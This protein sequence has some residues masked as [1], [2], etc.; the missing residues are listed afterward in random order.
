MQVIPS[1]IHIPPGLI[2]TIE[3]HHFVSR[4]PDG[5]QVS[6]AVAVQ[7][8][9]DSYEGSPAQL[10]FLKDRKRDA[11]AQ[12][13]GGKIEAGRVYGG[14]TFQIDQGSTANIAAMAIRAGLALANAPGTEPWPAGFYWIAADNSH[15]P[16]DAAAMYAFAQDV[17]GYMSLLIM[18]NR[19][20]KDAIEN[21]ADVAA[22]DAIDVTAGWP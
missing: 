12:V 4:S 17:G 11:L 7:A 18:T 14:A 6:D 20:F 19:A 10:A 8:I 21:A 15:V 5:W 16:M 2:E 1:P 3:A 22:L 9:I 13:F